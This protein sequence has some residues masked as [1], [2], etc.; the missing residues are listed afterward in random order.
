MILFRNWS[1]LALVGALVETPIMP[2]SAQAAI[3]WIIMAGA[4]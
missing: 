3:L 4:T 2:V 1:F